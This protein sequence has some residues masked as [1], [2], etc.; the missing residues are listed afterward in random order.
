MLH[1]NTMIDAL[2]IEI[3][4]AGGR[5]GDVYD[6]MIFFEIFKPLDDKSIKS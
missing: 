6:F 3:N 5:Q 4:E 2:L 1:N